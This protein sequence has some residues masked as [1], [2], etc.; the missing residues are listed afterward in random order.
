MKLILGGPS[1]RMEVDARHAANNV[2]FALRCALPRIVAKKGFGGRLRHVVTPSPISI[3]GTHY[4]HCTPVAM[5]RNALMKESLADTE[6]THY[7]MLDSDCSIPFDQCDPIIL[8]LLALGD[9]PMFGVPAPQ[10]N[11]QMNVWQSRAVK[12]RADS[13]LRTDGKLH[14]CWAVGFGCVVFNLDWYRKHWPSPPWFLDGWD[15]ELGPMGEDYRHCM[16]LHDK[17]STER[18]AVPLFAG[19]YVDHH[20]RGEGKP[21][22]PEQSQAIGG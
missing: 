20:D 4:Q 5:A 9:R 14:E 11:R 19:A 21:L 13:T 8:A 7:M 2:T 10:R 18:S 22:I 17:T 12:W 6:A 15:E 16:E 1:Y 3:V